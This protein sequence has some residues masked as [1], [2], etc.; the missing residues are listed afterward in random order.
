MVAYPSRQ[1]FFDMISDPEYRA[2][3]H[4]RAEALVEAVLQPTVPIEGRPAPD[5]AR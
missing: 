2:G 4:L 1:T 3:A 5:G